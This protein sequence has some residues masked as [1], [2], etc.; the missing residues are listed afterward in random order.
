M[1]YACLTP[2]W[3]FKWDILFDF[4]FL[5]VAFL[6]SA[7]AFTIYRKIEQSNVKTFSISFFFIGLSYLS[8]TLINGYI[9]TH[10][11]NGICGYLA[12]EHLNFISF[13]GISAHLFFM[14]LG[15][16]ILVYTTLQSREPKILYLLLG[17][18]LTAILLSRNRISTFFILSALYFTL[19]TWHFMDNAFKKKQKNTL[20]IAIS[21]LILTLGWIG[22]LFTSYSPLFYVTGKLLE[23][24]AFILIFWNYRLLRKK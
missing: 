24:I 1:Y 13:I 21:F 18:S 20:L 7:F 15:L 8:Q 4:L 5:C 10:I 6:I 12:L 14:L 16:S 22:F 11:G 2:P 19:I 23:L 17:G 3:F 9:F